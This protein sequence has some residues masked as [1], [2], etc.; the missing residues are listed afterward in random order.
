[1]RTR[2]LGIQLYKYAV[3]GF[4]HW[5]YNFYNSE[6]SL[7]PIDPYQCTDAD[8]AFPS[9]DPFL[10]YPGKDGKP[11]DSIRSMLMEKA[12]ADLRAMDHLEKLTDRETV[13]KCL[14]EEEHGEITFRAYPQKASYLAEVRENINAAIR[15][16]ISKNARKLP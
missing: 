4:L 10:V 11:V 5:G 14:M 2:I 12:M 13:M 6:F 9:G 15:A 3:S 7:Y 1:M 8:G 16:A